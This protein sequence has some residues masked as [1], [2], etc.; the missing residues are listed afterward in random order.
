LFAL[1]RGF[2]V[3]ADANTFN[4]VCHE[5]SG[6]V[7]VPYTLMT[8]S[9]TPQGLREQGRRH[10][11]RTTLTRL[12]DTL[13]AAVT[14]VHL[15]AP[16]LAAL[17]LR[18]EQRAPPRAGRGDRAPGQ[19]VA[20][21][22]FVL[23]DVAAIAGVSQQGPRFGQRAKGEGQEPRAL[24]L[25]ETAAAFRD[26]SRRGCRRLA[27]LIAQCA[28]RGQRAPFQQRRN[29]PLQLVTELPRVRRREVL[30]AHVAPAARPVPAFTGPSH[31]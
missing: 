12:C 22:S 18:P 15:R 17:R 29:E 21:L 16:G 3:S 27:Q 25:A 14:A 2:N 6:E 4:V 24:D 30:R 1:T 26:V 9:F 19:Q 28:I 23:G 7:G 5:Y 20:A 31:A 10:R 11:I 8:A 13:C